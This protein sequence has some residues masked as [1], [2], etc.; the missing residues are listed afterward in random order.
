MAEI[1]SV[2]G[3]SE[4]GDVKAG[5]GEADVIVEN[6]FSTQFIDHAYLE[7]ETGVAWVD[8]SQVINIFVG[9]QVLETLPRRGAGSPGSRQQGQNPVQLY[10][11]RVRRQGR[12]DGRGLPGSVGVEDGPSRSG[13]IQAGG[14][15]PRPRKA[16][17]LR[18]AVQDGHHEG[19][20]HP[21]R[22]RRTLWPMPE[23]TPT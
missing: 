2:N 4:R 3:R 16:A 19:W 21:P 15:H 12:R 10:G 5:F 7:T 22:W 1:S 6:E 18:D 9:T 14:I 13:G 11:R 23:P 17:S 20:T 8:E